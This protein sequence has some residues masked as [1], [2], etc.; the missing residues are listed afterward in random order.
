[1]SIQP[2]LLAI[3]IASLVAGIG[4]FIWYSTPNREQHLQVANRI[5][6]LLIALFPVCIIFSFFPTSTLSGAVV[7]GISASGAIAAF[8]L[9]WI[10]GARLGIKAAEKDSQTA[11]LKEQEK[12]IAALQKEAQARQAQIAPQVINTT[13]QQMYSLRHL[14]NKSIGIVTGNLIKVKFADIWVNSE[15]TNMQ[16]AG[17]YDRSVS[18]AIRYFGAKLNATGNVEEDLIGNALV[19]A[20]HGSVSVA[21]GGVVWTSSGE[22]AKTHQVRGILHAATVQGQPGAGYSQI[23]DIGRCV[24]SALDYLDQRNTTE[25]PPFQTIIFPLLGAGQGQAKR[26]ATAQAL[27]VPALDHLEAHPK[28]AITTVYFMAY[29]DAELAAWEGVLHNFSE[30]LARA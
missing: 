3:A 15:N 2:I 20:L 27:L 9:I 11:K 28:C 4:L 29:T 7:K 26:E 21:P 16:M 10:Q 5:A 1:M 6:W 18:G 17:F 24:T 19:Q 23:Q 14:K 22:L 12:Q 30:R 25:Q 13:K 8:V